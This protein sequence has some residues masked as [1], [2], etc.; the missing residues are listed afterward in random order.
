[1][2]FEPSELAQRGRETFKL[3]KVDLLCSRGHAVKGVAQGKA[4]PCEEGEYDQTF[5]DKLADFLTRQLR[6]LARVLICS[7][8]TTVKK[9]HLPSSTLRSSLPS[10]PPTVSNFKG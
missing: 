7:T 2:Y 9:L 10:S 5:Y 3:D 8:E 6:K 1:M 4:K